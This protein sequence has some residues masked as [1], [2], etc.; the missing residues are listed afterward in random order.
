MVTAEQRGSNPAPIGDVFGPWHI[1][2]ASDDSWGTQ[3]NPEFTADET[4]DG[5]Q[6]IGQCSDRMPQWRTERDAIIEGALD[7]PPTA[8]PASPGWP[9]GTA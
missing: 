6:R 2:G 7:T 4:V 3:I 8:E 9:E 5:A 1:T